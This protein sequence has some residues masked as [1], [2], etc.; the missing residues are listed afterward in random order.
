MSTSSTSPLITDEQSQTEEESH[1]DLAHT[2][3]DP[4]QDPNYKP[5]PKAP[6][7]VGQND[8]LTDQ[9][10]E[11]VSDDEQ[12]APSHPAHDGNSKPLRP[13]GVEALDGNTP[14]DELIAS[15]RDEKLPDA[16]DKT[17]IVCSD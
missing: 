3:V 4:Y 12:M 2:K 16:W 13:Q 17:G 14:E 15:P 1:T 6:M 8:S 5:G 11:G 10:R 9:P 7:P